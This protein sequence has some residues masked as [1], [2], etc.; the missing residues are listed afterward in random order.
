MTSLSASKRAYES[1]REKLLVGEDFYIR[2]QGTSMFPFLIEDRD[3]VLVTPVHGKLRR[4]D[5]ILYRRKEGL[6]VLHRLTR[7]KK[8]GYYFVG[9]NQTEVEGPLSREQLL[10]KV[11]KIYRNG[12]PYSVH[13]PVYI[14]ASRLWLLLRPIRPLI[15]RTIKKIMI[16]LHLWKE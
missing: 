6:L 13:H 16:I 1:I 2:P 7:I 12:T 8:D 3:Y 15:S 14:V 9:D 5:V 4:G 10:A 11:I